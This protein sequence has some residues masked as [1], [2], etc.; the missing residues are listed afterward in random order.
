MSRDVGWI[1]T[2]WDSVARTWSV[3]GATPWPAG[4]RQRAEDERDELQEAHGGTWALAMVVLA[5]GSLV[6]PD[7]TE[8]LR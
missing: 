8:A 6:G 2:E 5:E 3:E 1:V 7:A 4:Q